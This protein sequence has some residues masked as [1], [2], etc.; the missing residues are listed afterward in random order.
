[1]SD[2]HRATHWNNNL[3]CA[4]DVETTG[5]DSG[6]HEIIQIA[7][8]PLRGDLT[9]NTAI[10]PFYTEIAPMHPERVEKGAFRVNKLNLEKIVETG[11]DAYRVADLFD[12]WV[13]RLNLPFRK[14]IMPL[15]HNFPFESR[16]LHS[17][18]GQ[19]SYDSFFYGYRDTMAIVNMLNDMA[20]MQ[21]TPWPFPKINLEYV[22]SQLKVEN[23]NP[24]DALGDAVATAECYRKLVTQ[25]R[26]F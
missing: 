25:Y 13:Q 14:K 2:F 24:H 18:L 21:N 11:M 9:V 16:F 15:A 1:M 17:W 4:I 20:D 10:P 22:C 23:L 8:V 7:V 12:E 19:L 5:L 3:L 6:K 26:I